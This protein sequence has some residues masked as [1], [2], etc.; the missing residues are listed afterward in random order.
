ML[1]KLLNWATCNLPLYAAAAGVLVLWK[2]RR[3]LDPGPQSVV[4]FATAAFPLFWTAAHVQL[5]PHVISMTAS[6]AVIGAAGLCALP[7]PPAR[8]RLVL[9]M[10]VAVTIVW[11]G[12]QSAEPGAKFALSLAGGREFVDLPHLKGIAVTREDARWMRDLAAAL[13]EAAEPRAPLLML[14]NRNDVVVYA[15]GVPYWLSDRAMVTR[16]HE[17]HPGITDTEPVQ[18]R[19]L[20][21][22]ARG[23]LPVVVREHRFTDAVLEPIKAQFLEHVP[24][25]ST[26]LDGWVAEH[27]RSHRFFGS[28]ELLE[29]V[30]GRPNALLAGSPDVP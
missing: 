6:G 14:S 12:A 7:I 13:K 29:P 22:I 5:N 20:A 30:P 21:D 9:R 17:L 26:L 3:H 16:H 4:I 28:Y 27:Y 2:K 19:M 25:G 8:E 23:P 11:S 15:E 18:R 24:V 1:R 10:V